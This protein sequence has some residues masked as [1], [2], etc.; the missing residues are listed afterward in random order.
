MLDAHAVFPSG[1]GSGE[2]ARVGMKR[3]HG[4][5]HAASTCYM[6]RAG[7]QGGRASERPDCPVNRVDWRQ[8][9]DPRI[10]GAKAAMFRNFC[11]AG[12]PLKRPDGT[13][14]DTVSGAVLASARADGNSARTERWGDDRHPQA[15]RSRQSC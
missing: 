12:L 13:G 7:G 14:N 9:A 11:G 6:G 15:L 4:K 5:P 8:V 2:S 3:G 10:S 1:D